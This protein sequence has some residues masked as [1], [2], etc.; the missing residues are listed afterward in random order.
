MSHHPEH[1]GRAPA[2]S[3]TTWKPEGHRTAHEVLALTGAVRTVGRAVPQPPA[4][5]RTAVLLIP[6]FLAGDWSLRGM[7]RRLRQAGYRTYESGIR[8]NVGCTSA[9]VAMLERRVEDVAGEVGPIAIVGHSRGGTL[10]RLLATR[11]PDL[12]RGIVTLGS[13]L[14]TQFA[15]S[16]HVL[17]VAEQIARRNRNDRPTMLN[18][19]CLRG[20]CA[21]STATA[22]SEP[23]PAGTSFTSIYSR[24]DGIVQ[25]HA[26]LDPSA[27]KFE[28]CSTHN[29]M[30]VNRSVI[31]LVERRLATL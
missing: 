5:S 24:T 8:S 29:G 14:T 6:G 21:E 23:M 22:L 17:R 15:A 13:P 19:D 30:A 26:C 27:Q 28:V 7:G 16:T 12:V 10:A 18:V 11:R 4:S 2:V 20:S 1:G 9:T 31:R 3:H 25:W